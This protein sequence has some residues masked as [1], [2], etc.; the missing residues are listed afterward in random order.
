MKEIKSVE[1]VESEVLD[2]VIMA[3][4]EEG[5]PFSVTVKNESIF[6]RLK[7]FPRER[8]FKLQQTCLGTNIRIAKLL[9]NID[10]D[11]REQS[12]LSFAVES[13]I[14]HTDALIGVIVYSTIN[15]EW[16]NPLRA[17]LLKKF[18]Y[19]NLTPKELLFL[20]E[21]AVRQMDTKS[22]FGCS[23]LAGSL[24]LLRPKP[25]DKEEN[26]STSGKQSEDSSNTSDL[27][28]TK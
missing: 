27:A 25:G 9:K 15:K 8:F 5:L 6:H 13:S 17:Y 20:L 19:R 1:P 3:I 10:C 24:N 18:F 14:K 16:I 2:D 7:I 21:G 23:V 28:G 11:F 22:F 4:T 12:Y 26:I